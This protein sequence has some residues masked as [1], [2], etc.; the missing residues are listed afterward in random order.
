MGEEPPLFAIA[1][2]HYGEETHRPGEMKDTLRNIVA[3]EQLLVNLVNEAIVERAVQCGSDFPA[4]VSGP[5]AVGLALAPSAS[6]GVPR[7]SEA[8]IAWECRL[9]TV[10][11]FS[12]SAFGRIR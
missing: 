5:D 10:L 6:I 2:D 8:P 1:I 9:F 12:P 7:V 11:E 4:H 3:C